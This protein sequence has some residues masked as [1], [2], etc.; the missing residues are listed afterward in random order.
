ML[1]SL[2]LVDEAMPDEVEVTAGEAEVMVDMLVDEM[3]M[4]V[5]EDE[6][7]EEVL[8]EVVV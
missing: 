3:D 8:V 2:V 4:V 1:T 7:A 6:M 5:E